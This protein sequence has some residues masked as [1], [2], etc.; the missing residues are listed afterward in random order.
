MYILTFNI[1]VTVLLI[2]FKNTGTKIP[3]TPFN[4]REDD[5]NEILVIFKQHHQVTST[6]VD[7]ATAHPINSILSWR[8][9][10]DAFW[11]GKILFLF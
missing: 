11:G 10:N 6:F 7:C 8:K 1:I 5:Q 3:L 2:P 4:K 9:R